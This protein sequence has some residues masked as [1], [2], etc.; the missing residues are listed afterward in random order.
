MFDIL[1]VISTGSTAPDVAHD[2]S[3]VMIIYKDGRAKRL[4]GNEI[5]PPSLDPKS[6]VLS[7]DV[8]YSK[9]ENLSSRLFLPNNINPN[10]KL[11]LLLYFH[12]G[13]FGIET[14]FS[15][16][17]HGY[18]NTVVAES[19]IIAV[20]VDYRRI[21]EHP[22]PILY[23]DSWAAVKWAASHV[24]GDGPEEWLNSH[25]DFNKVFFAGDSAGANIAHHMAMR[26]GEERLSGVN[27]TGIILVHPFFWGKD[28]IAN[29][30][31]LGETIRQL[32][33]TIWRCACPTTSGCD[34]PLINPMKDPRLP[35]LGG[36]KVL[37]AAAGKD[38]LRDRGRLYCETL[39]SN[40]WGGRVEFMEAKEEAHVFHLPN[41]TC[42]NAVA[43]LRKIVS[44]IHE[45]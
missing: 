42:E 38:V 45:E 23:G 36:N 15:P 20:S 2:F 4:V 13:G 44:F 9:E 8:V 11:P 12:G 37:V 3:P 30:V 24:D 1:D 39:K 22:I 18:L 33:E 7:K 17:Y 16:T 14:P 6:N 40:G 34:D 19:Q 27:L 32:M 35:G 29:E 10:K 25:A 31:G 43:M 41:P 21:P 5:V 26:Y 28:P